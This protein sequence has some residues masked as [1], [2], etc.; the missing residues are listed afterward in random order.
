MTF[1]S[2]NNDFWSQQF[3][4]QLWFEFQHHKCQKITTRLVKRTNLEASTMLSNNHKTLSKNTV[5]DPKK[6]QFRNS[7]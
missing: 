7:N 1:F 5:I 4:Q 2:P 3:K 6:I